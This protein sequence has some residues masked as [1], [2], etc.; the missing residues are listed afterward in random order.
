[1]GQNCTG[2]RKKE[3]F[4]YVNENTKEF[5]HKAGENLSKG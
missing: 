3:Y 2:E 4:D 1:M 5:R